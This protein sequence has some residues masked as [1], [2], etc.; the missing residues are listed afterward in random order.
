MNLTQVQYIH[1]FEYMYEF[2]TG[3]AIEHNDIPD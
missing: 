1:T 2:N 3:N